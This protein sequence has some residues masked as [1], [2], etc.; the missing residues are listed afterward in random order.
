MSVVIEDDDFED[1]TIYDCLYKRNYPGWSEKLEEHKGAIKQL[2]NLIEKKSKEFG[3][4]YPLKENVFKA[5]ELTPL[6]KVKV[7]IW[8]QDPYPT[9]LENGKP[10]AQGYSFGVHK[11]DQVPQSLKNIYKEIKDNFS[12]FEPPAHGDLTWLADQG[13]L[14]MNQSLTYCPANPKLYLNLWNR[15]TYIIIKILNE[16]VEGCIHLLWGKQC[17]P[18]IEHIRSREIHQASHPSPFSARRGFFGCKHFLKVNIILEN[19]KKTKIEDLEKIL[20]D[21]KVKGE[22]REKIENE[23]E[24]ITNSQVQINWNENQKLIP[25]YL[26]NL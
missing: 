17:E 11:S 23:I 4:F 14:F 12:T 15:F 16:N 18:L 13:I 6:E 26:E 25:T 20:K 21:K 2:S 9:L 1:Y 24:E 7:V 5:L 10:R 8:G 3:E 22:E 19:R